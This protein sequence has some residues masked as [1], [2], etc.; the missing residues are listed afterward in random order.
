[1]YSFKIEIIFIFK[2]WKSYAPYIILKNPLKMKKITLTLLLPLMWAISF[3][4]NK[5][6]AEKVVDEGVAFHDKGDYDNAITKY[7]KALSLDRDNLYALVEKAYSYLA[8]KKYEDA[9]KTSEIALAKHKTGNELKTLFVTYGNALDMIEKPIESIAAYDRGIKLFPEEQMLY[10]NKAVTLRGLKRNDEAM[11]ALQ[12]A[13]ILN[14]NHPGSHNVISLILLDQNNYLGALLASFRFFTIEPTGNRALG[15]LDRVKGLMHTSVIDTKKEQKSKENTFLT[16]YSVLSMATALDE[17]AEYKNENDAQRFLR[18]FNAIC[19][20][21]D[22]SQKENYGFLWK[23]YV[24]Y[25]LELKA[26]GF[27]EIFAYVAMASQ[28]KPEF[29]KYFQD[30]KAKLEAFAAWSEGYKWNAN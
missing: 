29:S 6:E 19:A 17:A 27:S 21:L 4:Q 26:K 9:I 15:V 24:P 10:F 30:N 12:K 23:Y 14:P 3:A 11:L 25:F 13:V 20:G 1:M 22:V 7:D 18:K 16:A 2:L 8:Q 5:T 28:Q